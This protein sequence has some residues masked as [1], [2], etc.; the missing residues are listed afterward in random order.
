VEVAITN[1]KYILNKMI[2]WAVRTRV[3]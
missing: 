2:I 1:K 3:F